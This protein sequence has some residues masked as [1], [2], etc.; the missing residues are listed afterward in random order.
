MHEV[1]LAD[2]PG[3]LV[4]PSR[5]CG[6]GVLVL[7]GSS[8]RL[9]V[10]RARLLATHGAVASTIRW[11]GDDGPAEVP[12]ERFIAE[13][14]RLADLV[15]RVA[16]M[17]VSYGAEAA[18]LIA[19]MDA[20]VS[21]TVAFAPT[22]VAW[23]GHGGLRSKWTCQGKPLPFVPYD[24]TW[25]ATTSPP[26]YTAMYES[27]LTRFPEARESARIRV[28]DIVGEL[29]LVAGGDDAVWPS[30][31]FAADIVRARPGT[32][33]V[34]HPQGGHRALLP[35]E[36]VPPA[37]D[38]LVHGGLLEADRALGAAAWVEIRRSLQLHAEAAPSGDT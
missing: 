10:G 21:T 5:P 11:F 1:A 33:L 37:R 13:I 12:L 4:H 9:D 32:I 30:A 7:A 19:S 35:G 8:G 22:S 29:I 24:D 36:E 25:V 27:S 14:D 17:G 18:L 3:V 15:D 16:I 26:S 28:E 20:R 31:T 2:P 38:D 34:S 23:Q 6:T